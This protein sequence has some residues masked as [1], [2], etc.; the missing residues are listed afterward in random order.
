MQKATFFVILF[1]IALII[2][3]VFF[4]SA[5]VNGFEVFM[6]ILFCSVFSY[7]AV[8]CTLDCY[9]KNSDFWIGLMVSMTLPI[10]LTI[11]L[12]IG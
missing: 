6:Y 2:T 8:L 5:K 4:H 10:L 12:I 3:G 7:V 1:A 9:P 11:L